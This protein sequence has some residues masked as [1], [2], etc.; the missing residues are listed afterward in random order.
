MLGT[1]IVHIS[2]QH[3]HNDSALVHACIKLHQGVL[4]G[5]F[6]CSAALSS[7]HFVIHSYCSAKRLLPEQM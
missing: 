3:V 6:E 7:S 1:S 2:T 4:V 5:T